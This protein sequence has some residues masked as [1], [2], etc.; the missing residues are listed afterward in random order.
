MPILGTI[1]LAGERNNMGGAVKSVATIAATPYTAPVYAAKSLIK[2]DSVGTAARKAFDP[3]I[4][5]S[6]SILGDFTGKN[7][8]PQAADGA[9]V[10]QSSSDIAKAEA[11]AKRKERASLLADAPGRNQTVLTDLGKSD[12]SYPYRLY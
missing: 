3:T 8:V 2:G 6:V 5:E 11:D 10:Q 1:L 4:K 7:K 12:S 9:P